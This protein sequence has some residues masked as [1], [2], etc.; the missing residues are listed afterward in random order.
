M[1]P[2]RVSSGPRGSCGGSPAW[3]RTTA[4]A[5]GTSRGPARAPSSRARRPCSP[6]GSPPLRAGSVLGRTGRAGS[7]QSTRR[8][9]GSCSSRRCPTAAGAARRPPRAWRWPSPRCTPPRP[10]PRA[11]SIRSASAEAWVRCLAARPPHSSSRG[12]GSST[13]ARGRPRGRWSGRVSSGTSPSWPPTAAGAW[14]PARGPGRRRGWGGSMAGLCINQ[15]PGPWPG[16]WTTRAGTG[17]RR[18]PGRTRAWPGRGAPGPARPRPPLRAPSALCPA[19]WPSPW[20]HLSKW[21]CP[22]S[23]LGASATPSEGPGGG[24]LALRS[25]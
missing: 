25:R 11:L 18:G 22:A 17:T 1:V 23:A 2:P 10:R 16:P 20:A 14:G 21:L 4:C 9:R 7:C 5:S 24:L 6:T 13:T 19:R 3:A 12:G 8:L 15:S